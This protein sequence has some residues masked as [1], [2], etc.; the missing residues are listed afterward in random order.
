MHKLSIVGLPLPIT[1]VILGYSLG[2]ASPVTAQEYSLSDRSLSE[3]SLEYYLARGLEFNSSPNTWTGLDLGLSLDKITHIET[4]N[5]HDRFF[6]NYSSATLANL[7]VETDKSIT[8]TR[9]EL[10]QVEA[11]S[12]L[13]PSILN[14]SSSGDLDIAPSIPET[15]LIDNPINQTLSQIESYNQQDIARQP[16]TRVRNLRDVQKTDWAYDALVRLIERYGCFAGYE[17]NTFKGDRS[18][19]RYEFAAALGSCLKKIETLATPNLP[20]ESEFAE[21][22]RLQAEFEQELNATKTKTDNLEQRIAFLE[23]HNFSPTTI[24]RG[25]VVFQGSRVFGEQKAVPSG[26]TPTEDI[27]EVTT[28]AARTRLDFET[29]FTGKD[30]LRT[31]IEAGNV[32]GLGSDITGTQMTFLG[33][34]T[35]TDNNVRLGQ[36]FYR[37][38]IGDKG[39]AYLAGA[40]QSASAFIPTLNRASTISLFGF[41]NPLYDIGFGAGGG[42]YYQF[43]DTIGAGA[44]YYSGSPSQSESGKGLFN[45]DYSALGQVTFTPS[46]SL[47]ISFTYAHFF[48]PEPG[49]TNNVTSFTGSQF[50]QLPFGENTAT[51]SDNFNLAFSY[52][53]SDRFEL[54]GWLGYI[55]AEAESSP[56]N[57]NLIGSAGA[58]ADI[59]TG[60]LTASYNDLG[61][62]GSRLSFILGLPAKL[63]DNDISGR[64]DEDTS[65]HLEL[66]YNYPLTEQIFFT[67]GILAITNPEHNKDNDTILVGLWQTTF[68]F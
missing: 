7:Q 48:S 49:A 42:V 64:E 3:I 13:I 45:G 25:Q 51:A 6:S 66:S 32:N 58:N 16:S 36:I 57:S 67:P 14:I 68:S 55:S 26:E 40:R 39:N 62:L 63:S 2:L 46:D 37:F 28:F 29:S 20:T 22:K 31:R 38:P 34:S 24:L 43:T 23:D 10:D 18:I 54:G 47:G 9:D 15:L 8:L 61:K 53:I 44:T 19:T 56:T 4:L 30:L 21:L 35:N 12:I 59:W 27:D 41:N 11:E 33:V 5:N 50:A 52:Q 17:D 60:A 1:S 65:L